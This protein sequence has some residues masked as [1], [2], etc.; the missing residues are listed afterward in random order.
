V[1]GGL[2]GVNEKGSKIAASYS[3]AEV[4]MNGS[5]STAGG[6][7]GED[8]ATSGI[9]NSYWDLETSGISDPSQ[10]AGNIPNDP[11]I[12]GLTTAQFLSGLPQGFDPL[13]WGQRPKLNGGY[14]FL[15][16]NLPN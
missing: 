13:I 9:T 6:V 16:D 11:G 7:V 5:G 12:T 10:G 4:R 1:A 2:I 3:T 15:R 14:P 8:F